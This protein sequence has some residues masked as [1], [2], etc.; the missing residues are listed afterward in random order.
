[1]TTPDAA[2]RPTMRIGVAI[3]IAEQ[4]NGGAP[5][6][7]EIRAL[8]RQAE[9]ADFDSIWLFDHLLFRRPNQSTAG[10]WE[11]WTMLSALAE[12]TNRVQLGTLVI[13]TAFRN[14][15]V[16][17]KMADTLDA[18]SGG[19]LILGLGAGWHEPEFDAFGIPFDHRV[20]RFEEALQIIV[21]LL[22]TG[23]VD[24]QGTYERAPNCELR[25]RGP[26]THGPEILIGAGK[27]RMLR[28]TAQYADSWN[29]CWHGQPGAIATPFAAMV[30]A[31]N[32][33]GRDPATLGFTVGVN[34][35]YG[36]P[37]AP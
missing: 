35:A 7:A 3:P 16:L 37:N 32:D 33:V 25:P 27:P 26:R 8:A 14:P 10:I 28:L 4:L 15:A 30:E 34:V 17:A 31:C 19:R 2:E 13:C 1:M 21:P 29:T 12:A 24:F 36:A 22:R 11:C 9:E 20:D 23:Q 6:Y 5:S 18:I